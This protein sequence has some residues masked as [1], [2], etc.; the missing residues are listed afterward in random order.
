MRVANQTVSRNYLK[1]LEKN[2][3]NVYNSQ[4]KIDSTHQYEFGSENPINAAGELRV[5]KAMSNIENY[6]YNLRTAD[7]IYAAA[8]SS[9]MA[10]SEIIQTTY[11]KCIEAANGTSDDVHTHAPDQ[12]EMIAVNV[13]AYADEIARLMNLT[14]ADRRIFGGINNDC[15]AFAIDNG[16]V[17]YNGVDVDTYTDPTLFPNSRESYADI[18]LGMTL[19]EDGRVDEQSAIALTF[20]GMDVTGCG[21]KA[22]SPY[23]NF[24]SITA[25]TTYSFKLKVGD[26]IERDISFVGGANDSDTVDNIN[27]AL[28]DAFDGNQSIKVLSHGLVV[29]TLNKDNI[30]IV[31]TTPG[32]DKLEIENK[33]DEYSNNIIQS[34]LDAAKMIRTGNGAEIARYA[35]HIYSLQTKVSLTL[36]NIGTQTKFIEFNQTRL[37]N[38]MTTLKERENDLYGTDMATESTNWK[39]FDAIY[40]ATLQMSAAVVPQSIFDFMR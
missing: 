15:K 10:I 25:G 18:G 2:Y 9:V 17:I 11:E 40:S 32:T 20:N 16:R 6:Q 38:N 37:T 23:I 35:D 14:V 21:K 30:N 36:A 24:D 31:D 22:T 13:E 7:S 19:N 4:K 8:E 5:R 34:I 29:N 12:L 3:S 27:K 28:A 39:N 26:N 1:H 33:G